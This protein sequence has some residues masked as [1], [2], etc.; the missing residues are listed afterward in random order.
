MLI[1]AEEFR[2]FLTCDGIRQ[3]PRHLATNGEAENMVKIAKLT[4]KKRTGLLLVQ[5]TR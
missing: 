4:L 3:A 2:T 5:L 1:A